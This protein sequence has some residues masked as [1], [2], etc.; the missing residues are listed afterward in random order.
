MQEEKAR[1]TYS[2]YCTHQPVLYEALLRTSG[3]VVEFG[4][5]YGSTMLMHQFCAKHDRQ[6]YTLESDREWL[7]KF[8]EYAT[9]QH[10]FIYVDDWS[11]ALVDVRD[12][13]WAHC[14]VALVDQHPWEARHLTIQAIKDTTKFIALH[15]CDYFPGNGIFG[16]SLKKL[17]GSKDRG[18]RTYDDIFKYY[19]EFF[20]LEPWPYPPT[21]PPT[22]LASNFESCDWDVD[23]KKYELASALMP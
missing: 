7:A 9:P 2:E 21:G 1:H 17:N 13:P 19:K 10:S 11:N 23:F 18:L 5:G 15:D 6:L 12:E 3:P 20:P 16:K 22:L 14:D 8:I 4:C